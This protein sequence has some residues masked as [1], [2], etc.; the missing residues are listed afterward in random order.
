MGQRLNISLESDGE[1]VANAYYHW[2]AYTGSAAYLVQG[3]CEVWDELK[4]CSLSDAEFACRLL[5]DTGYLTDKMFDSIYPEC[6]ELIRILTSIVNS[7]K[8]YRKKDSEP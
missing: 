5:H 2:S 6:C 7:T 4:E 1:V 8:R 3:I